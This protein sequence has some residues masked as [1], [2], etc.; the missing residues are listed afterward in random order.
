M[1]DIKE[2]LA[3]ANA[4]LYRDHE[5][6][7][8][9]YGDV[10]DAAPGD[11]RGYCGMA[12]ALHF[13]KKHKD[14]VA[15]MEKLIEIRPDAAYP[16]GFMGAAAE[17]DGEK[18]K[19]LACY[20]KMLEIDP[21]DMAAKFKRACMMSSTGRVK[22]DKYYWK[23]LN[24]EQDDETADKVRRMLS[25]AVLKTIGGDMSSSDAIIG[26]PGMRQIMDVLFEWKT[27]SGFLGHAYPDMREMSDGESEGQMLER[28]NELADAGKFAEA[29][30]AADEAIALY[31]DFA[32]AYSAKASF[33][34]EMD[35]YEEAIACVD[36]ILR[37]KPDE[38]DDLGVKGMLLERV[39]RPGQAAAC[40]ERI[41]EIDPG[42]MIVRYFK[43][44]LLAAAGDA[45]G[46]AECYRAAVEAEP[47]D[48]KSADMQRG[49]RA[50]YRE[51]MRRA[52]AAGS[53]EAGFAKFMR[54]TGV[55]IEPKWGR[56]RSVAAGAVPRDVDRPP[57]PKKRAGRVRAGRR[58]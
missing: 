55:G 31:P 56:R 58:R 37:I 23:V 14:V 47:K 34:T 28:A 38:T 35:R 44:G 57:E 26:T 52:K 33:L 15:C 4:L 12:L 39:G 53:L 3:D 24:E 30:K 27:E 16:H 8:S 22:D 29:V 21:H 40:Y 42:D 50:E 49:M 18:E 25:I 17:D 9:M 43:C 7:A 51:L 36:E 46:L 11:E 6:A 2:I 48:E 54:K 41:I 45:R 10:I 20:E 5:R 32:E 1:A 13:M 19:A